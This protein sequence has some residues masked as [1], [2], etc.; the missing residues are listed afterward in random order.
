MSSQQWINMSESC[1]GMF[2]LGP[3]T[4][5][6]EKTGACTLSLQTLGGAPELYSC[7]TAAGEQQCAFKENSLT[8][9]QIGAFK[10]L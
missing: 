1:T 10:T 3:E 4:G 5:D 6:G 9:H 2:F 8:G 7:A